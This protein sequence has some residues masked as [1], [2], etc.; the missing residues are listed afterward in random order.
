MSNLVVFEHEGVLV[1]DSRLVARELG[2][3]HDNFMGN[4][5]KYR[6][7][8]EEAFGRLLFQ[9]GAAPDH[10]G[11]PPQYVLLTEEQA[12]FFMTLSRNT[13]EVV[14]LKAELVKKFFEARELLK[15]RGATQPLYTTVYIQR[16][17]NM[18]D[19]EVEDHLWT[20]FREGAEVLLLVEKEYRVPVSKMDLCD[21]SIGSHWGK[22]REDKPWAGLV[23]S[24]KHK[25]RDQRNTRNPNAYQ[26]TELS[27]FRKWLREAYNPQ[28][29][30]KYLVDKY[31]K[32]AVRQIF[33]ELN[34]LNEYILEITEE[35]K[36][37][38]KQDELYQLFLAARG[39]MDTRRFL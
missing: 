39:S 5:R 8:A 38:A 29:L 20:T 7:P 32:R 31:G 2:I 6:T 13:P 35:K 19:H 22:Y 3:A 34:Q 37:S 11:T 15:R 36:S 9:T 16:L 28:H 14:Q 26:L 12:T 30:P 10:G 24:Y 17:E 21:G 33:T 1:V 25:F 23:E 27:Y 18:R 4:V